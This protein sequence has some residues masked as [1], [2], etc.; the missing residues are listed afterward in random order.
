MV[1]VRGLWL[2]EAPLVEA[3][4]PHMEVEK[5]LVLASRLPPTL[6]TMKMFKIGRL[7]SSTI[8]IVRHSRNE[9]RLHSRF[10]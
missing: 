7:R 4:A 6:L 1:V 9:A 8:G 2:V 10:R 3:P 5:V